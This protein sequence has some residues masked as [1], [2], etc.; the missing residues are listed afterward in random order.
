MILILSQPYLPVS[1]QCLCSISYPSQSD[2]PVC[3]SVAAALPPRLVSVLSS[4]EFD[5]ITSGPVKFK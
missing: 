4:A 1:H 3:F 5:M 2:L